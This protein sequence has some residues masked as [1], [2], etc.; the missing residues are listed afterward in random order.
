MSSLEAVLIGKGK[1]SWQECR[2]LVLCKLAYS[3][4]PV[5]RAE[6]GREKDGG[7][8]CL[9]TTPNGTKKDAFLFKYQEE[10]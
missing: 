10:E 1:K 8:K 9:P 3:P 4:P 7:V 6:N 5:G 2:L